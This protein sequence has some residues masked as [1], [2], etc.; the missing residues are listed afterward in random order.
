MDGGELGTTAQVLAGIVIAGVLEVRAAA[1]VLKGGEHEDPV[2][3][4]AVVPAAI[5]LTGFIAST[6]GLGLSMFAIIVLGRTNTQLDLAL[7]S[8]AAFGIIGIIAIPVMTVAKAVP[9][10][11]S[12]PALIFIGVICTLNILNVIGM[13]VFFD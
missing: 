7:L 9:A 8:A 11:V 6:F 1:R 12:K 2:P 5:S 10:F 4:E 3:L 13:I